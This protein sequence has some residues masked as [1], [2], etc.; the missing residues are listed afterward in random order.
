MTMSYQIKNRWNSTVIFE[1]EPDASFETQPESFQLGAAVKLAVKAKRDLSGADL[2]GADLRHANLSG[3]RLSDARLSDARLC[4]ASLSGA[5]LSDADL[6]GANLSDADLSDA[7]LSDA[8]LSGADLRHANLSGARLSHADLSG[9]NLS[10]AQLEIFKQDLIA[11][12]LKLPNEIEAFRAS[13]VAGKIDGSTYSGECAC[14]AGTL[15]RQVGEEQG[16]DIDCGKFTFRAEANAPRE[17]WF[18]MIKQG[19]TP[20]TNQ[21]AKIALGWIDEA[22]AIRDNIRNLHKVAPPSP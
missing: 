20:E 14:L 21:A 6:S 16:E 3:A 17:K 11:E 12:I 2:S 10:D 4:Y 18:L 8:D 19:D 5:R 22:I 7:D 15:A 9:A 1:A 13:L